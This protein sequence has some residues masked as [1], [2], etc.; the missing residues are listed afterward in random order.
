MTIS[1]FWSPVDSTGVPKPDRVGSS[2]KT[3]IR[4]IE[5][6]DFTCAARAGILSPGLRRENLTFSR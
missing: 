5:K 2:S 4:L 3:S 6:F 1:G